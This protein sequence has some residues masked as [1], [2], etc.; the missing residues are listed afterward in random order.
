MTW[1]SRHPSGMRRLG[2]PFGLLARR[3]GRGPPLS[4][5]LDM[6]FEAGVHL[7]IP[8][9]DIRCCVR[10]I[11]CHDLVEFFIGS[12]RADRLVKFL[13]GS[14]GADRL[15]ELL[16]GSVRADCLVEL[17]IRSVC[18]DLWVELLNGNVGADRFA[19]LLR[20]IRTMC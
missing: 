4:S 20:L 15:V 6:C 9:W 13:S 11:C 2:F 10:S 19:E 16:S 5:T 3:P 12:I 18:D 8:H 7:W 17:L 14:V 1:W